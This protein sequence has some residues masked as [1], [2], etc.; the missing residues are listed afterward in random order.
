MFLQNAGALPFDTEDKKKRDLQY[1]I[2]K[3]HLVALRYDVQNVA[4]KKN[5]DEGV[6]IL[7]N[8]ASLIYCM[9]HTC[10]SQNEDPQRDSTKTLPAKKQEQPLIHQEMTRTGRIGHPPRNGSQESRFLQEYV[11]SL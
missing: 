3:A 1:F 4:S 7:I 8:E 2:N 11:P 5:D 6:F 10:L 9:C